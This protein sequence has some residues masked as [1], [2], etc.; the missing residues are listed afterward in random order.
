MV[1]LS[2]KITQ[3]K[4]V[5]FQINQLQEADPLEE[6]LIKKYAT[7][8][9][10]AISFIHDHGIIHGDIKLANFAIDKSHDEDG[11]LKVIDFGLSMFRDAE[12]DGKAL[13][14]HPCGS[15]GYMAPEIRGVS[16]YNN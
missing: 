4:Y 14:S 7:D 2:L 1:T 15:F 8:A 11:V 12:M 16:F 9:L 6:R 5:L 10:K 3:K 13:M